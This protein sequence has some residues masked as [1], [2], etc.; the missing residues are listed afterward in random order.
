MR[1]FVG[2]GRDLRIAKFVDIAEF[3]AVRGSDD[4]C[5]SFRDQV[6]RHG[7]QRGVHYALYYCRELF[8]DAVP[9]DLVNA[10]APEDLGHLDEYGNLDGNPVKWAHDF[11]DRLFGSHRSEVGPIPMT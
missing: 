8:P 7:A 1:F 4:F 11:T 10:L 9:L 6:L 2:R 3:L 5:E